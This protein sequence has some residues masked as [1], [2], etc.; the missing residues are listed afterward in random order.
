[1]RSGHDYALFVCHNFSLLRLRAPLPSP[2]AATAETQKAAC[3]DHHLLLLL[4]LSLAMADG[5][6]GLFYNNR[7]PSVVV[8]FYSRISTTRRHSGVGVATLL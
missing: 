5:C 3:H 7:S 1:M 4:P 2:C 8:G 6:C